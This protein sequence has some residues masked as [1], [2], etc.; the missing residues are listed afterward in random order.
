G[1]AYGTEEDKDSAAVHRLR[2]MVESLNVISEQERGARQRPTWTAEVAGKTI[3]MDSQY[4][5]IGGIK[6]PSLLL[7]ALPITLPQGNFDEQ[8]RARQL[9]DMRQDLMQAA[10][11][12]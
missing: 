1:A 8:L 7:A 9:E 4:I 6:I 11:R 12:T 3:G 10:R 5:H 2:S